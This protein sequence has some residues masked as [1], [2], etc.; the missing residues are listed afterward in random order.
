[1]PTRADR[2][3]G[4]IGG[5]SA[6]M[7]ERSLGLTTVG[8]L[9]RHYPRRMN[10]RGELTALAALAEGEEVTVQAEGESASS[11]RIPGAK[12]HIHQVTIRLGRSEAR[13]PSCSQPWR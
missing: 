9:I 1:M 4:V 8:E 6:K 10:K 13:L 11:R 12:M 5:R 2:L 3:D 7:I